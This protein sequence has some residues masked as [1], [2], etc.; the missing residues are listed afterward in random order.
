MPTEMTFI[1]AILVGLLGSTHC[2]GMCGGIVSTLSMGLSDPTRQSRSSLLAHL[3][4]YN[5]GRIS[6][7]SIIGAV[8]GLIGSSI[9]QLAPSGF[10][11][12]KIITSVFLIA[13][14]LYL[15]NWWRA[16]SWLERIGSVLWRRIEPFGRRY[17][18]VHNPAHAFGLGIVWGWLPCGLVYT[19]VAW[20]LTTGSWQQG[21]MLMFGFG[22]G[23]LPM[24]LAMGSA[25]SSLRLI[26]KRQSV[27]TASGIVIILL[28]IYT[29]YSG[30]ALHS[31]AHH[32]NSMSSHSNGIQ[33]TTLETSVS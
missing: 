17:L 31:G 30:I 2:L 28:G 15:A 33:I 3:I 9:A 23:T 20:S 8:S 13:L 32:G 25:A 4:A 14:G 21:A 5:A 7:Y 27:R 29:A 26:L 24:L 22:L 10:P 18:P 6:S 1:A 16:L 12:G 19:V 11:L